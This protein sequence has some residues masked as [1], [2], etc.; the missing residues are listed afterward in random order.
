MILSPDIVLS[1]KPDI[2]DGEREGMLLI[3][4][5]DNEGILSSQERKKFI[6]VFVDEYKA[7]II[8]TV[9]ETTRISVSTRKTKLAKILK[10]TTS[11][12]VVVT[13][14]LHGMIFCAITK[15]PCVVLPINGDKVKGVFEWIN[16]LDY[17][18][19]CDSY[20]INIIKQL[21][22]NIEKENINRS[23]IDLSFAE[24]ESLFESCKKE[25]I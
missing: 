16:D 10:Q 7:H 19:Y 9:I 17:I 18:K 22:Q 14:R 24:I 8:D 21:I 13:N 4:R 1:M 23:M 25:Y 2:I 3:I 15:T 6:R 5:D 12:S 11:A 20:D